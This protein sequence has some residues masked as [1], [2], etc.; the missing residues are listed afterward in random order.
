QLKLSST[1]K[2]YYR[3]MGH[4]GNIDIYDTLIRSWDE[5]K[6]SEHNLKDCTSCDVG[7][8]PRSYISCV[9]EVLTSDTCDGVA[10]NDMGEC[11]MDIVKSEIG[12]LGYDGTESYG[13]TWKVRGLCED[14]SNLDLFDSVRVYGD[15]QESD[16]HHL[17]YGQYS[18]GHLGGVWT[19]NEL[20]DNWQYG[21]DPH[22]DSDY[23]TIARNTCY[24]N[25]NHG[26]IASKRCDHLLVIDNV[27]DNNGG[28]GIM[29]HKSCDDSIVSGNGATGNF[30]A[31]LSLVETSRTTVNTNHFED[32]RWG[33]RV[34]LGSTD[35]TVSE[36][37]LVIITFPQR[38]YSCTYA[39]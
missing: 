24:N 34:T 12:Y 3:I 31:G 15:L 5:S 38:M 18:Y 25:G 13:I 1:T 7:K 29:L 23:L 32:N 16:V 33:F 17:W 27:S 20:H 6:K 21:F 37:G 19:D 26:I 30:D 9:S 8:S 22:D 39:Y 4:G 10:Q 28:S 35:N 11:R 36:H 14:L 2:K